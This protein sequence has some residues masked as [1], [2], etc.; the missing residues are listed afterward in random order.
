MIKICS[1]LV[2][3]MRAHLEGHTAGK[4]GPWFGICYD[5]VCDL[6]HSAVSFSCLGKITSVRFG[7]TWEIFIGHF[8][9][10][11]AE[12]LPRKGHFDFSSRGVMHF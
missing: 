10:M 2:D 9:I 11:R 6:R 3:T 7:G 1:D 4:V 12:T 8:E 5:V